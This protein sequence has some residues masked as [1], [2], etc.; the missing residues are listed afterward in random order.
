LASACASRP[1][2]TA[3]D[4][5]RNPPSSFELGGEPFC[6]VGTNN[7]YLSYKPRPMVD[8]VLSSAQTMGARVVR[9]WAFIDRGSLDG[10]VP[11]VDGE[12][13][14][15]GVYFQSWDPSSGRPVFND[16]AQGLERLD[17][18]LF[19]A[20]ALGLKLV[21]VLTN[22]WREFGGM[23]QYLAWYGH[24]A[25]DA[26]YT[27][28]RVREAYKAW[29]EH[30]AL[31]KNHLTGR[32][33]RDDPT[34]FAWEL[35]NEPRSPTGTE[36]RVITDWASDMSRHLKTLDPN[37]L[38]A[39]GDEGFLEGQSDHWTYHTDNG[40]DHRALTALPSIDYG[41]FHMYPEHWGTGIGWTERWIDDHVSLARELGKPTVLEEY[42][43][44]VTRDP[45]GRITSGLPERLAQYRAWNE[46][47]LAHGGNAAMFWLLAGRDTQRGGLYPDYDQYSV[48]RGDETSQ[49]LTSFATRFAEDAPACQTKL[50]P[51]P[52]PSSPFVRVRRALHMH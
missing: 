51:S 49:L 20:E 43:S 34:I 30:L 33:Y 17:Y 10:S 21:L 13:S 46:R 26:F 47:L 27:D 29:L 7:Y 11:S 25:H 39:V 38:V 12:G 16:G 15:E 5:G 50:E 4:E 14:K 48:Y 22:N 36:T 42:G 1:A 44:K 40:V 32:T 45:L 18:A 31:R 2:R 35:A 41:T 28:P 6:F 9:T 8:D 3:F 52:E 19:K 37:H 23:A 24:T